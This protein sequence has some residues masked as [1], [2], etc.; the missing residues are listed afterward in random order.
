MRSA[1]SVDWSDFANSVG[2][3]LP[4]LAVCTVLMGVAIGYVIC[5]LAW[6]VAAAIRRG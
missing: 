4:G 6:L 2:V 1:C 5:R 3:M